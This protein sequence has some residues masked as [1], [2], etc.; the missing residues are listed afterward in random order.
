VIRIADILERK[1][2]QVLTVTRETTVR[3]VTERLRVA[4]VGAF[5]VSRDGVHAEGIVS[6]RE[7]VIGLARHG[8]ALLEMPAASIMLQPV[9]ACEAHDSVEHVMAEMTQARVRH[10][11]VVEQERLCGI[12]SIGDLVSACLEDAGSEIN[13]RDAELSGRANGHGHGHGH[14]RGLTRA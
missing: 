7:I 1:G 13:L 12:I 14:T 8:V 3:R 9:R 11:P 10:I 4:R 5:V 6:E 2:D